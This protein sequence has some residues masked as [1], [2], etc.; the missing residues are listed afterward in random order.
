MGQCQTNPTSS[1][2]LVCHA[3]LAVVLHFKIDLKA[4]IISPW[5]NT[6]CLKPPFIDISLSPCWNHQGNSPFSALMWYLSVEAAMQTGAC[7]TCLH[8][9]YFFLLM[10]WLFSHGCEHPAATYC[11]LAK[12]QPS[13]GERSCVPHHLQVSSLFASNRDNCVIVL[14]S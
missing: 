7:G 13:G 1:L 6:N 5:S 12:S 4:N 11:R 2:G 14:P 9:V 10:H 8:G 3:A